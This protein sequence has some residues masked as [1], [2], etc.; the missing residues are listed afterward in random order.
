MAKA[1]TVKSDVQSKAPYPYPSITNEVL[2]FE[3]DDDCIITEKFDGS[4]VSFGIVNS[5]FLIQ[6]RH[7]LIYPA[8]KLPFGIEHILQQL[9]D[10]AEQIREQLKILKGEEHDFI[11]YG[12][13]FG[14]V[15]QLKIP[16]ED[17]ESVL[18]FGT[19]KVFF[20]AFDLFLVGEEGKN[21]GVFLKYDD[22][23]DIFETVNLPYTPK[24][25]K[26]DFKD[27]GEYNDYAHLC[28][29]VESKKGL[30]SDIVEGFIVRKNEE[31]SIFKRNIYKVKANAFN[32]VRKGQPFNKYKIKNYLTRSRIFSKAK[33]VGW[34]MDKLKGA[35]MQDVYEKMARVIEE[36]T[37][38][39][40][41][42][43]KSDLKNHCDGYFSNEKKIEGLR[44]IY[45][46]KTVTGT[47]NSEDESET[48]S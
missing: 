24:L 36:E 8:G 27:H 7:K 18:V 32:D 46:N 47:V 4:N 11:V 30:F 44:K 21:S 38:G 13:A 42:K 5:E 2:F 39:K 9:K 19:D 33:E 14:G 17:E 37:K 12:E 35:V 16:Y 15:N 28:R 48:E 31:E 41:E 43:L 25:T 3:Y 6:S 45:E 23:A 20:R 26:E 1:N 10:R 22:A 34:D 40:L 29:I